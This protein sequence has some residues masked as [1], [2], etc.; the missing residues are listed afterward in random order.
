VAGLRAISP[1]LSREAG[2]GVTK[3]VELDAHPNRIGL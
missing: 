3:A 1:L 2:I